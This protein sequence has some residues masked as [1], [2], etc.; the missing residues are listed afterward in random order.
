MDEGAW[1][2]LTGDATE[3]ERELATAFRSGDWVSA[4]GRPVRASFVARLVCA[5]KDAGGW[6]PPAVR[7]RGAP[8]TGELQLA[9]AEVAHPLLLEDCDF[10]AAPILYWSTMA[11][12]SFRR[13]RLPG[14]IAS[15][16]TVN[17][18]LR[19]VGGQFT[20]PIRLKGARLRGGLLLDGARLSVPGGIALDA[21]RAEIGGDVRAGDGFRS[22]GSVRLFQATVTGGVHLDGAVIDASAGTGTDRQAIDLDSA[23][24][25]GA[26][27]ARSAVIDGEVT[28]RHASIGGVLTL[29]GAKVNHPGA[30]AL[31]MDRADIRGGVFMLSGCELTGETRMVGA[32]VSRT[33]R[34]AGATMSN[35]GGNALLAD[36]LT[37]EGSLDCREGFTALGKVSLVEARVA[38][39]VHFERARLDNPGGDSLRCTGIVA[40]AVFNCCDGFTATGR[41][42][43]SAARV[44]TRLCFDEAHLEATGIALSCA[45]AEVGELSLQYAAVPAGEVNLRHARIGILRDTRDG[46]PAALQLDG[47]TYETLEPTLPAA[48]RLDWL[49][50]M[51]AGIPPQPYEQLAGVY[52]RLGHDEHARSILL[53]KQRRQRAGTAW[54]ARGWG[55]LQ[56]VTIGYGYRPQRAVAWLLALLLAGS[57]AFGLHPPS[58]VSATGGPHFNPVFYTVDLMLPI[59][60]FGQETAFDPAGGQQWLAYFLIAAG[61]I[62]VT[63]AAA[64]FTRTTSR[65]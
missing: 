3:V 6:P 46:W 47:L 26:L 18:H 10:E 22:E 31:R 38:G 63:T 5:P 43:F 7:L 64:G 33:V 45:R 48:Q 60:S 14:M 2:D 40:G 50:R 30:V 27:F 12:T 59:V 54:Y 11:F 20:G 65:Y 17:G 21:E 1:A 62:L 52:R 32:H 39:P 51:P 37:V 9:F 34:L 55:W 16:V 49:A 36:G 19:L 4:A 42:T 29:T 15:N 28:V 57:I 8:L 58:P 35:P 25:R 41:V 23:S 44:A 13:S 53:V 61:W 56:D 24:I